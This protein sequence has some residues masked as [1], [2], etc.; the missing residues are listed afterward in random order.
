MF[1]PDIRELKQP[2]RRQRER[3]KA[4]GLD[5]QSSVWNY[6]SL[7]RRRLLT[8]SQTKISAN[9]F[10]VVFISFGPIILCRL[11]DTQK[12]PTLRISFRYRFKYPRGIFL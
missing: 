6:C 12:R 7:F 10:G 1:S 4:M 2:R 11:I 8:F 3:K 9:W 5:W